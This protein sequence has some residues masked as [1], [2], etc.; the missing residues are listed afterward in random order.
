MELGLMLADR[1]SSPNEELKFLNVL[2]SATKSLIKR[3]KLI[4]ALTYLDQNIKLRS[5][6]DSPAS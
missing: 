1:S 2:D 6:L 5:D 4:D 3:G